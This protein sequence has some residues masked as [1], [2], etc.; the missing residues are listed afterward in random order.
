MVLP[1]G[2]NLS[3]FSA[4]RN[5]QAAGSELARSTRRLSSGRQINSAA[6]NP[7]G[8]SIVQHMG[9]EIRGI[10]QAVENVEFGV[11]VIQTAGGALTQSQD[12][13]VRIRELAVQASNA[14]LTT[15]DRAAIAAE[16]QALGGQIEANIEGANVNGTNVLTATSPTV[17]QAGPNVG[18]TATIAAQGVQLDAATDQLNTAIA[19][20][21]ANPST[22]NAEA[23][24]TSVDSAAQSFS[25]TQAQLG[26]AQNGFEYTVSRLST[27]Q[28]SLEFA[29]SRIED[30]DIAAEVTKSAASRIRTNMSLALLSQ[31]NVAP[32][33]L[34]RFLR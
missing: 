1:V 16:A 6:D 12:A 33:M 17:I 28:N 32:E 7:A 22:A 26:A 25:S 21:A 4:L 34:L 2:T 30:A 31:G 24:I 27:A 10:R 13:A 20:F 15:A 19:N 5:L 9:A 8:L 29:R 3:A 23:L 18:D 14:T 11:S